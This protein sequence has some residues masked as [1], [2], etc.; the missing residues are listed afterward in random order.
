[1]R[2]RH[3]GAGQPLKLS[4]RPHRPQTSFDCATFSLANHSTRP[5]TPLDSDTG[6]IGLVDGHCASG[7][8]VRATLPC[9]SN[10]NP[11]KPLV[12][13]LAIERYWIKDIAM[14]FNHGVM[15]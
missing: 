14:P 11:F 10:L 9:N 1:M 13:T 2:S 3:Q 15:L 7:I 4:E 8:S 6:P 5:T 12:H